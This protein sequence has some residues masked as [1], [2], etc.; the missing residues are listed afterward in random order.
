MKPVIIIT[1]YRRYPELDATLKRIAELSTEFAEKPDIVLVWARPEVTRLWFIGQLLKD[2]IVNH[3]LTRPALPGEGDTGG[4]TTYPESH[5]IRLGL[6][7]VKKHYGPDT[8]ALVQTADVI[9]NPGFAYQF[10]D[11]H[12][13]NGA[14]AVVL[15]WENGCVRSHIWHTNFFACCLDEAYWPPIAKTGDD[16]VLERQ[17]GKKL[18]DLQLPGIVE[19]HNSNS[20]R[21]AHVHWT[22]PWPHKPVM[23]GCGVG[24]FIRGRKS[25]W[26]KMVEWFKRCIHIQK[27]EI[28]NGEDCS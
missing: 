20:K 24:L 16:D 17:Y 21:F 27:K 26:R 12:M 5:N 19:S 28:T 11:S 15:F 18:Q 3:L 25:L 4:S 8:Y 13:Q 6:E 1:L 9:A 2:G 7:F 10:V 22:D 14:K 23:D